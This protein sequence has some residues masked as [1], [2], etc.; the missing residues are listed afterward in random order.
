MCPYDSDKESQT[1]NKAYRLCYVHF[2]LLIMPLEAPPLHVLC[3]HTPLQTR[4]LANLEPNLDLA[5][6][7]SFCNTEISLSSP[8]QSAKLDSIRSYSCCIQVEAW[9]SQ[10]A[11]TSF[12]CMNN[13][14]KVC[15][16]ANFE[17]KSSISHLMTAHNRVCIWL[18]MR[19]DMYSRKMIIWP[20]LPVRAYKHLPCAP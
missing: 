7:A 8:W 19:R 3:S 12:E 9:K 15:S 2:P 6:D 17:G 13:K 18:I 1:D 11:W 5:T 14:V 10:S 4:H 16:Q 20:H